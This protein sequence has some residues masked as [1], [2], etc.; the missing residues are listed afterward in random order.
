[1][2]DCGDT[3]VKKT[4]I[5]SAQGCVCVCVTRFENFDIVKKRPVSNWA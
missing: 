1:M 3:M 4:N 2:L 5:L